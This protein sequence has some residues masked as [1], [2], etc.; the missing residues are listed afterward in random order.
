[1]HN[2]LADNAWVLGPYFQIIGAYKKSL[3]DDPNPKAFSMT[4]F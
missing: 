4:E 2:I 1:M 3:V